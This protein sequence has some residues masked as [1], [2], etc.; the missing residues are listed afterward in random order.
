[1]KIYLLICL[2]LFCFSASAQTV[3]FKTSPGA[4]LTSGG[5]LHGEVKLHRRL[6]AQVGYADWAQVS[7]Q[8]P[9]PWGRCRMWDVGVRFYPDADAIF[10]GSYAH[11]YV[12]YFKSGPAR[13]ISEEPWVA[14]AGFNLGRRFAVSSGITLEFSLGIL[15]PISSA[16]IS[17]EFLS[18]ITVG[19]GF[20][21]TDP[22][23]EPIAD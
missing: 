9:M 10:K 19:Y 3:T 8:E 1:M 13:Q 17:F 2:G 11:P 12:A 21:G 7:F 5:S 23:S 16:Q 20:G 15:S 14:A 18:C 4:A 22:S 6:S